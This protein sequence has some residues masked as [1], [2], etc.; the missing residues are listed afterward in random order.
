MGYVACSDEVVSVSSV[1]CLRDTW[2]GFGVTGIY[3]IITNPTQS[4]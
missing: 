4:T 3:I 2:M 1:S